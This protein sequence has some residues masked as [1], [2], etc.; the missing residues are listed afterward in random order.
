MI[1]K[2]LQLIFV[3][4]DIFWAGPVHLWT[5]SYPSTSLKFILLYN[6]MSMKF[7]KILKIGITYAYIFG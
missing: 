6:T 7:G 2:S 1:Y 3:L 4:G 5:E